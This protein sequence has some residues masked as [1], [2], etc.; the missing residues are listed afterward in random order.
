MTRSWRALSLLGPPWFGVTHEATTDMANN[1]KKIVDPTEAA[2]SAIQ[3]ALKVRDGDDD[4]QPIDQPEGVTE[5]LGRMA[6]P[7]SDPVTPPAVDPRPNS[8]EIGVR[9]SEA[10]AFRAANDDQ[11]SIGQVLQALQQRPPRTSYFVASVFSCAW[12]IGCLALS[13]AYLGDLDA[14][15]GPGHSPAAIMIGLGAAALLPI[16]FFFGVAHMAWRAQELRLVAQ[17]MAK[18]AMRL[19]EPEG[20][21]RDSVVTVGQAIRREVAAMGDGVERALARASELETLVHN[22][23]AALERTYSDNEVRIRGLLQEL[24]NQR[25]TLV[26]QAEL[27][28]S[29]ISNVQIDLTQDLSTISDLVGQQVNE[30]AERITNSLAEKGKDITLALGQIG[31]NMIQQLSERGE[32]LLVRLETASGETAR[33]LASASDEL[34]A[35]LNFKT[36]HIGEEFA[37]IAHGLE[38]MMTS[39]LDRVADGFSE[40][41]LAII[42]MMV[43]RAQ[44]LTDTIVTTSSQLA[45]TIATRADE[46]NGTL[47]ASGESIILDL[48]L[49][50]GD[51]AK[52]LEQAGTRVTE[53]LMSRS[54]QVT[55]ALRESGDRVV[56][57]LAASGSEMQELL[58][59]RLAALDQV[60]SHSGIELGE[61]ISRDS[62]TLGN[63][64]TRHLTEF[65]RTVKTYGS[66]LV[67]RL[68]ARTQD[69]SESMRGYVDSFDSRVT[70]K[71]TEVSTALDQRLSHFQEALDGT[72]QTLTQALANRITDI[73]KTLTDG[74][75]EVVTAVEKRIADVTTV[76]DVRGAKLAETIGERAAEIDRALSAQT[77]RVAN[78][79]DGRIGQVEQLLVG[80]AEAAT[81][82]IED[83]SRAAA[84]LLTAR[85]EELSASITANSRNAEQVIEQL[86]TKTVG[87]LGQ[88]TAATAAAT[89]AL[90]RS[91]AETTASLNRS[92]GALSN[93]IG[94][95]AAAATEAISNTTA[96]ASQLI[97]RT[98]AAT[99][100]AIGRNTSEAERTLTGV[101]AGVA[102]SAAAMTEAIT[103]SAEEAERALSGMSSDIMRTAA[104]TAEAIGRSAGEA[105]RTLAGVGDEVSRNVM[106][107]ADEFAATVSQRVGEMARLLDD[108]SNGLLTA[109]SG[110]SQ[111][112]AGE[113]SRI[114]DQAVKSIEAKSFVFTQTMLDNSEQIARLINE[115]SETA[116]IAMTRTL[117]ELQEGAQGASEAAKSTVTRTLEDLRSVTKSAVDESKQIASATVADMLKTHGMLRTDT[118]AMFERL[119][120]ANILLQE[121]LSGAHEN[122]SS[123]ERTMGTRV[124]EFVAAMNDLS[125][126]SDT[127][128][129]VVE[130]HVGAFSAMTSKVVRELSELASQFSVQ[131][132]SLTEAVELLDTSN[133]RTE[134]AV[135]TRRANIEALVST[136][137]ARTDDFGQ[138]LQRFSGLLDE[139]L[140]A[141]TTRAREIASIIAETSNDSV[142]IIE[143]QFELVRTTSQEERRRTS[144]TLSAVYDE[145]ATQ[146]H[147]MFHQTAER[148]TEIMQGMKQMAAEMQQELETT[149]AEL[150]R[151]ILELPQETSESAAQMRRVI[152]DQ[153]EALAEL[154][155]IVARH[156]RSLDTAEPVRREP[157]PAHAGGAARTQVRPMRGD[158]T[159]APHTATRGDITGAPARRSESPVHNA[160]QNGGWLSDLLTRASREESPPTAPPNAR[161]AARG[162]ERPPRDNT[163]SLDSLAVDITRMIDH[164]AAA[165]L[166]ERYKRGER[167]LFTRRLYTTQGQKS[168]DEIRRKYRGDSE[169]RQTVEQYIHEFER[170]LEDVSRGDRG[171]AVVRNYLTS[172]TGKVYTMLA[173]AAGRFDQ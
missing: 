135:T 87:A 44:E 150:R 3:E 153:I 139:S 68:G 45:E 37:Q 155:R 123:L 140:D 149:R 43:G 157:E 2:L 59:T 85:I 134:E 65:E 15:L 73:A 161:E 170:L 141:A 57:A 83:R 152:V 6:E 143:Q 56:A 71:A 151:G 27:V 130:Q 12:V 18:V 62:S 127:S 14:A 22:E 60:L 82:Q 20:V 117:G 126:K 142:Q 169:F 160:P 21:A 88:S 113:V 108:R 48:N 104:S 168:F 28:R 17:S 154:N 54:T 24:N 72:A 84:D 105:G 61:K 47:K 55:V 1:P 138:R 114:T 109:L 131:G 133:R 81:Q 156:G 101:S 172:D 165:D 94:Q 167:G 132:R 64:I 90:N 173:H 16:I 110:K 95:S 91:A 63:L 66:E 93:T 116:T 33:A 31:D 23:I 97:A 124:S 77:L 76:I 19:A 13:W 162:E 78:T 79:L 4:A 129:T 119:R 40:K 112:F 86:A 36:D 50:G 159:A 158:I 42:D 52:K 69:V 8:D 171:A 122:M 11:Q 38:D 32:D 7:W 106:G 49:R 99:T 25:D 51:V 98:A 125:L 96:T 103:R 70:S 164:E 29:A 121:V 46:V 74:G 107:R 5:A 166:W 26:G 92:A 136:L 67:E 34:S 75:R 30:A 35:G 89:E 39:R 80:R 100:E 115:A 148:F 163:D 146:V 128:T 102:R 137:D 111:E 53:D 10:D 41:S 9:S 58:S 147:G 118:T 145:A 120:E 144:E